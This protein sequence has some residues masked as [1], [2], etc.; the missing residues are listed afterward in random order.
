M[1][2]FGGPWHDL[3]KNSEI[4]DAVREQGF[5]LLQQGRRLPVLDR[6]DECLIIDLSLYMH[7]GSQPNGDRENDLVREVDALLC[8]ETIIGLMED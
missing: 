8:G 3:S 5:V 1:D 6:I 2:V 7:F 4:P